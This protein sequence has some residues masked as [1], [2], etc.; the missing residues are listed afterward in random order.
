MKNGFTISLDGAMGTELQARGLKPGET[1]EDWNIERPEDVAAV[2][3]AY[4]GA[5]ADTIVANTFGANPLKY[6]GR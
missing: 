4:V 6:H 1:P 3:R 5:G 2:H